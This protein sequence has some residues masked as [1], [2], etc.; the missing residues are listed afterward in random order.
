MP[1]NIPRTDTTK[2]EIQLW[3]RKQELKH[4]L[5]SGL[6]REKQIKAAEKLRAAHLSL[7]KAKLYWVED[8]RIQGRDEAARLANIQDETRKWMEMSADEI[9]H[10][11][12]T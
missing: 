11:F 1:S 9:V 8:A 7:L 3:H 4:A 10:D 12:E 6:T 5:H 2:K